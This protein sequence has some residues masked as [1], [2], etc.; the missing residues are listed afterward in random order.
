MAGPYP[1]LHQYHQP[2]TAAESNL[3]TPV[4]VH[5]QP[6]Q[7]AHRVSQPQPQ[8][9]PQAPMMPLQQQRTAPSHPQQ[10]PQANMYWQQAAAQQAPQQAPAAAQSWAYAGYPQDSFPSVPQHEP[11]K[12]PIQEEALIEF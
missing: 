3:P 12:Q 5:A 9:Q 4:Q 10:L 8:T 2:A 6:M 11:V 7:T 1:T